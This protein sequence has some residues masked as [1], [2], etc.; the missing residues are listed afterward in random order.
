[1]EYPTKVNIFKILSLSL[2]RVIMY[3][4][5]NSGGSLSLLVI[6]RSVVSQC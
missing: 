2:Q 3:H 1:M 6:F 4:W 5:M